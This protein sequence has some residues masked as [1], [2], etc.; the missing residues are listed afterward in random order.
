MLGTYGFIDCGNGYD[1]VNE[2]L[3]D[4]SSCNSG[5]DFL[6]QVASKEVVPHPSRPE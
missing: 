4:S 6:S 2:L 5:E 3:T 1:I